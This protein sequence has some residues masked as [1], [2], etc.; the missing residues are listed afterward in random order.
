MCRVLEHQ[1]ALQ[2]ARAVQAGREEKMAFEQCARTTEDIN[3]VH[4]DRQ[5]SRAD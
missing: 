1:R 3:D 2:I 4:A 5:Y